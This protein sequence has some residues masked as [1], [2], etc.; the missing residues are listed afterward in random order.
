MTNFAR[1]TAT[2]LVAAFPLTNAFAA[3]ASPPVV[4]ERAP[5]SDSAAL[6][7]EIAALRAQNQRIAAELRDAQWALGEART[8]IDELAAEKPAGETTATTA[9]AE[10]SRADEANTRLATLVAGVDKLNAEK[11]ALETQLSAAQRAEAELKQR[12]ANAEKAAVPAA[13]AVPPEML[14]K[15][16]ETETKLSESGR[17]N[18]L[19]Q[20]ENELLKTTAADH[21]R[22]SSDVQT[23]RQ[24]KTM[25]EARLAKAQQAATGATPAAESAALTSRLADTE[26]KLSTALRS[27]SILQN[28]MEQAKAAAGKQSGQ[29]AELQ[30]LRD[31]KATLE[32]RLAAV[33]ADTSQEAAKKLAATEDRLAT[34]LRS[35]TQLQADNEQLKATSGRRS[36]QSAELATLRQQN[37]ALEARIAANPPDQSHHL[38]SKLADNE[39]RLSTVLR[40]YS[41]LQR[42]VDQLKADAT[43]AANV[44]QTAA[45]KNSNDSASQISALYDDL[46]QTQ[47]RAAA[48]VAENSQLKTRLALVGAPPGSTLA[49]PS[50][51]GSPQAI[52]ATTESAPA[53]AT[54]VTAAPTPRTH[55]V[56][57]GDTLGKISRQY[58]GTAGR[59]EEILRANPGVIKTGNVL[60]VGSTLRIP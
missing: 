12:L 59:W 31:Q 13:P 40:S 2:C 57:A 14:I 10:K 22:L 48:L 5:E 26:A 15:L 27:Y 34:V 36:D 1:F 17:R 49:A 50:R 45:A 21:A 56:V 47:A 42:E 28:E 24:E 33:P 20:S 53:P 30:T 16:A 52:S 41:L 60:S 23:L 55:L 51:P 54:S 58:Y 39:D 46:R 4:I 7:K 25:L 29:S 37:A 8:R 11:T 3:D 38:A 19:L 35:Y 43:E 18:A 32:A 44:T 9:A 6:Q